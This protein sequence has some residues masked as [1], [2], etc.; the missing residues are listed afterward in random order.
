MA[1]ATLYGIPIPP[2][3]TG[4]EDIPTR[5]E[6]TAHLQAPSKNKAPGISILAAEAYLA[7]S[8]S[9]EDLIDL[10]QF[11]F[12]HETIM[13]VREF[14]M[15]WKA[16]GGLDDLSQYRA[17]CLEE[18]APKL[19]ASIMLARLSAEV[20]ETQRL[21][22]TESEGGSSSSCHT[23]LFAERRDPSEVKYLPGTQ[24]GSRT[25]LST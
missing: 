21:K 4:Y 12:R 13:A 3:C 15:L 9:S 17:V 7:T 1:G 25:G 20:G 10:V 23:R 22:A 5:R 24:A 8:H 16:K 11:T 6:I 14:V 19:V 2:A 18:V